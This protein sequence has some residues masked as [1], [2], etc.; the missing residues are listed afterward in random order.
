MFVRHK[1][2]DSRGATCQYLFL[3]PVR[4]VSH[5]KEKPMRIVWELERPMPAAF[6]NEVKVAAGDL[7]WRSSKAGGLG[8]WSCAH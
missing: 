5:E 7:L 1:K 6:F 3:G 8:F 2:W 4:Y